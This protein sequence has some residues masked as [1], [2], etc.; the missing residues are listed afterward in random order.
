M[1]T[2][3]S[4][5]KNLN[6]TSQEIDIDESE[7]HFQKEA[8]LIH[9][10]LKTLN[11]TSISK[12]MK[13]SSKISQEVY[14]YYTNFNMKKYPNKQCKSAL[15]LF[16]GDVYKNINAKSL[17]K[18]ELTFAQTNLRILS[19]LY[20]LLKPMDLIFPYRL[21]MGTKLDIEN[22][23]LYNYWKPL[24]T[25]KLNLELDQHHTKIIVNLASKEYSQAVDEKKIKGIW[26][27]IDF[28]E[29]KDN[30]F[31]SIGI[32]AKR[33]RGSMVKYILENKCKNIE[34]I[35]K[36]NNNGYE[37]NEKLSSKHHLVFSR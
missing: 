1:I 17:N 24:I 35:I 8:D 2:L 16:N 36:F 14:D 25:K 23:K 19:G 13:V 34:D 7:L 21:E 4:P 20:G 12:L 18:S 15:F 6:H 32:L 27:N 30:Q 3:I 10:Y 22:T 33:A 9:N 26:I 29:H 37:I 11:P 31:K 28:K 5:A